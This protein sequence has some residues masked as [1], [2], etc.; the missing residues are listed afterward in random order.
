VHAGGKDTHIACDVKG[1][2]VAAGGEQQAVAIDSRS[3][4]SLHAALFGKH[5]LRECVKRGGGT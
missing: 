3:S 4:C 1:P 5:I 2:W